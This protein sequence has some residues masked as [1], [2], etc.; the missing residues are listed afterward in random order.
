MRTWELS[1]T[2]MIGLTVACGASGPRADS[3]N[4]TAA[5]PARVAV[6]DAQAREATAGADAGHTDAE[7]HDF[8]VTVAAQGIAEVDLGHLAAQ[9]GSK[10]EVKRFG[11]DIAND[12]ARSGDDLKR[13]AEQLGITVPTQPDEA[14]RTL[15]GQLS[16]MSGRAFDQKYMDAM[17]TEHQEM[18][19]L[20]RAHGGD[21]MNL[22]GGGGKQP[23][24]QPTTEAATGEQ[25]VSEWAA[26]TVPI[27][28]AHLT[29][30]REI[31]ALVA[32]GNSPR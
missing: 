5:D 11:Q 18:L 12:H 27:V 28:Q 19:G 2:L 6:K 9:R 13:L 15:A 32:T 7:V 4:N 24:G 1:L 17:V 25:A 30:A 10:A 29:R 22:T 3:V 21:R 26:K 14:H 31:Q 8:I 20:L 23:R 16:T